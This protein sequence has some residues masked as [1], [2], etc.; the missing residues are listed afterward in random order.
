M[1]L[2]PIIM[3]S[4]LAALVLFYY[5]PLET[6]L[7][8]YITILIVAAYCYYVMFKSMMARAKTGLEAMIGRQARVIEDINPEG[9]I[10]FNNEIW[11]AFTKGGKIDKGDK[12]RILDTEG[13]VLI[14]EGGDEKEKRSTP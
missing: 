12:V 9:K 4:P 10:E 3:I 7:L 14:V 8:F 13:L 2:M 6:A 1:I 5:F 11:T